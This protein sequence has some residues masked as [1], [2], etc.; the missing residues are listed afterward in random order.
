MQLEQVEK[1]FA[2]VVSQEQEKQRTSEM[3]EEL[4]RLNQTVQTVTEKI[5]DNQSQMKEIVQTVTEKIS[6]NQSQM[7]EI[8]EKLRF[9]SVEDLPFR[10]LGLNYKRGQ[11]GELV[12]DCQ[13]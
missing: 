3:R 2:L 6:N 11:Y 4:A 10:F 13:W 5:T 7:K 9:G 8:G 12:V 1:S